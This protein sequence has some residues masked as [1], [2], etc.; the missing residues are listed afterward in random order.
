MCSATEQESI[1]FPTHL[2][3]KRI[4]ETAAVLSVQGIK[5][6]YYVTSYDK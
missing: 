5:K 2:F 4:I 6:D 3:D 1:F